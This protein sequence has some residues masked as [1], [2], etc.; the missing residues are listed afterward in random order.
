M[1][2]ELYPNSANCYDSLAEC[3]WKSGE[4]DLAIKNYERALAMDPA[5]PTGANATRML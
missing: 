2:I 3:Y 1:S 5:D 4:L